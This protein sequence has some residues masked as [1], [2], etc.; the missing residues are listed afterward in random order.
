[1]K[2]KRWGD[3]DELQNI[4]NKDKLRSNADILI[5]SQ[6]VTESMVT[7]QENNE[8]IVWQRKAE[9]EIMAKVQS[10]LNSNNKEMIQETNRNIEEKLK[11]NNSMLIGRIEEN[12]KGNDLKMDK[13]MEMQAAVYEMMGTLV[14]KN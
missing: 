2:K 6:E 3:V 13:M 10:M 1:M 4:I 12:N 5:E 9:S 14:R 7:L 11:Q 8:L